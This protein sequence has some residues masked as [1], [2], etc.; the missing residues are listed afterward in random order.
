ITFE[1]NLWIK[2]ANITKDQK[3]IEWAKNKINYKGLL[4]KE[5]K[6]ENL[7]T[8][9][10]TLEIISK[11]YHKEQ[12]I[13]SLISTLESLIIN[14]EPEE[15]EEKINNINNDNESIELMTIHKSKG[16]S[17]NIV[18]LLN[19]T[20]IENSNFF[21]KKNQFYKFYQDGK[22]EYDFFKLEENK[23]YARLKILSEEKNI[24]Y[25]GATRAKF[26][27]F[28]IKI[29]SITSKL[30]EIAK[31]F[32]I[33]DIKHDFNIHEFIGQKRFNKKKDN[34]N[35]NTKLIPPKPI[36]KNMFKKEYTSSFSSLTAQ[37]HHKEFYENYDF[38]NINY[39]KE[40]ELDYEPGLEET[41]PKGKDIGNILHA[42]MEE[43]IFSTAKDTF[44]NFKKNNI[45]IIEKQIQKINS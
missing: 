38:K 44:D 6:L 3:I 30:L 12:N 43:I 26:A 15:I 4:I 11:I 37:A 10:T 42:A 28:I 45:E 8:Y 27:L 7:K 19:T 18:F 24:F 21:S 32:T 1:K 40:T 23:K 2:I 31:I 34:T 20:P 13:Q 39:E 17:M 5:G 36:I 35:V 22:I 33:D 16:L 14:E 25:V 41:M 29:N 9:E